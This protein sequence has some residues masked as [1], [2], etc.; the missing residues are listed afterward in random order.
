MV[1]DNLI[2]I[3][4]FRSNCILRRDDVMELLTDHT[5]PNIPH[6]QEITH[7]QKITRYGEG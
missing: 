4:G 3:K 5:L 6:F 7:F 2:S 1:L